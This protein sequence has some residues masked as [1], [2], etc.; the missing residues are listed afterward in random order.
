MACFRCFARRSF[1]LPISG[2]IRT[3]RWTALQWHQFSIP[4]PR[5][6]SS[7]D[8][9]NFVQ[10]MLCSTPATA[11]AEGANSPRSYVVLQELCERTGRNPAYT[12]CS[13]GCSRAAEARMIAFARQ[14]VGKPFSN[15]GMARSVIFPR[16]TTGRTYYCAEL[17]AAILKHGGLMYAAAHCTPLPPITNL[18][19]QHSQERRQQ[20]GS[21]DALLAVQA[22]LQAG[23]GD[24]EPVRPAPKRRPEL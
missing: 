13:L 10:N 12:Y 5:R 4:H 18:S 3:A 20:P 6:P 15:S 11:V 19:I 8:A 7:N 14:Q 16:Q 1:I 24:R 21:R 2:C 22:V 9:T 23:R 17:V